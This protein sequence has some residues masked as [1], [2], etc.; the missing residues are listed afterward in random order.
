MISGVLIVVWSTLTGKYVS[1]KFCVSDQMKENELVPESS[2]VLPLTN[3]LQSFQRDKYLG[4]LPLYSETRIGL[5]YIEHI[6]TDL[7]KLACVSLRLL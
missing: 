3:I 5:Q 7:H 1:A 4:S 2:G 6:V